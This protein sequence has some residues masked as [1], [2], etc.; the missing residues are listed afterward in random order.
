MKVSKLLGLIFAVF[1]IFLFAVSPVVAG[2]GSEDPWSEEEGGSGTTNTGG[3][4]SEEDPGDPM[5]G[6]ESSNYLG[7]DLWYLGFIWDA[8][9]GSTTS[10]AAT[11]PDNTGNEVVEN[12]MTSTAR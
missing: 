9:V 4:G 12:E 5:I 7:T 1:A 6:F 2:G 11:A 8:V 10:M 3:Q